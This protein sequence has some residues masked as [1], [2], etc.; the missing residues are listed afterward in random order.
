MEFVNSYGSPTLNIENNEFNVSESNDA[1]R[2]FL[3]RGKTVVENVRP[4]PL[5]SNISDNIFI[6]GNGET[7]QDPGSEVIYA[8]IKLSDGSAAIGNTTINSW[9]Y[10]YY[11]TLEAIDWSS[12]SHTDDSGEDPNISN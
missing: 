8:L 9:K 12:E 5:S 4:K 6:D 11:D 3:S 10:Y 1:I 2:F 7:V